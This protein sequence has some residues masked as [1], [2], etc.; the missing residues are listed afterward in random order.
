MPDRYTNVCLDKYASLPNTIKESINMICS[1][2]RCS[3]VLQQTFPKKIEELLLQIILER[4]DRNELISDKEIA[5]IALEVYYS[6]LSMATKAVVNSFLMDGV[7][8]FNDDGNV[9]IEDF[10]KKVASLLDIA[11]EKSQ[12]LMTEYKLP[13][14][15]AS[16]TWVK[17]FRDRYKFSLRVPHYEKRR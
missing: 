2:H 4:I 7:W 16:K 17:Q 10:D 5:R 3:I 12:S 9:V 13:N 14:F 6:P 11:T 8:P 15:V 1:K